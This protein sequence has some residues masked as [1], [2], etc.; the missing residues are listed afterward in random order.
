[1]AFIA[2]FMPD[3]LGSA[4][5]ADFFFIDFFMDFAIFAGI[6]GLGRLR[7]SNSHLS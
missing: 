3:F 4:F 5:M 2:D 6:V 1:M 7:I